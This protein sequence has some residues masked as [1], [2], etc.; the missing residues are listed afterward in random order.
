MKMPEEAEVISPLGIAKYL[1]ATSLTPRIGDLRE[2]LAV[3]KYVGDDG[4]IFPLGCCV[5]GALSRVTG[6]EKGC[7][8]N[9]VFRL[10]D[11]L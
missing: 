2:A 9:P 1:S 3:S 10:R 7:Y 4:R 6:H 8:T 5:H 11:I